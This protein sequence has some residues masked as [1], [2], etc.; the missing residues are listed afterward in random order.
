MRSS[1]VMSNFL[2]GYEH[3]Y[4]R[5]KVTKTEGV[6]NAKNEAGVDKCPRCLTRSPGERVRAALICLFQRV[7]AVEMLVLDEPTVGL[8][9]ILRNT[10]WEYI[11]DI[12][13]SGT[14]I[15]VTSHLLDEIELNC[16]R[17]GI[18]KEGIIVTVGSVEQYQE[19][20]GPQKSL[21]DIFKEVM[22]DESF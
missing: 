3:L 2:R 13:N 8:D 21:S 7:P 15:L 16:D 11:Q 14:T 19:S 12:H 10:I 4:C 22:Y 1:G 17:I 18:L 9:P 5:K 6:H 20:F